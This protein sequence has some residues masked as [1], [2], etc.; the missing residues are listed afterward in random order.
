MFQSPPWLRVY[1]IK[2][3]SMQTASINICDRMGRSQDLSEFKRGTMTGYY[4]FN[5]SI[6]ELSLLLNIPLS[7][8]SG[9][10]SGSNWEQQQLSCC[11]WTLEQWR[12]VLWSEESCFSVWQS[13]RRV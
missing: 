3:L 12:H 9:I 5:K 11:H 1:K 8:V 7:T 2:H 13:D 4:L 10:T 6:R